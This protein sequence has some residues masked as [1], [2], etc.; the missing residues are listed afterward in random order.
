M[1]VVIDND[2]PFA[3]EWVRIRHIYATVDKTASAPDVMRRAWDMGAVVD[4]TNDPAVVAVQTTGEV[5]VSVVWLRHSMYF[6][7]LS[8][9]VCVAMTRREVRLLKHV[10]C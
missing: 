3:R 6:R 5:S 1:Q 10:F 8:G 2:D 4:T 9:R 7:I